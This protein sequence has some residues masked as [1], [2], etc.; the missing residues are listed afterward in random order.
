MPAATGFDRDLRTP[1]Q[2]ATAE[3]LATTALGILYTALAG[4]PR[5]R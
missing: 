4:G 5:Q 2:R 3:T 1:T